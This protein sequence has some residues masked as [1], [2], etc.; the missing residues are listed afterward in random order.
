MV[1]DARAHRHDCFCNPNG[2]SAAAGY[3]GHLSPVARSTET[4]RGAGQ[5][6]AGLCGTRRKD[7]LFERHLR[8]SRL[9]FLVG[10]ASVFRVEAASG[11]RNGK[12]V[13]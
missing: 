11:E 13:S 5:F 1:S 8:L 3:R 4:G 12:S 6:R 7:T 2:I 9:S 10:K